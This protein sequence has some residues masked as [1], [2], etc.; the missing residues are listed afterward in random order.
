MP[1]TMAS[2]VPPGLGPSAPAFHFRAL[3]ARIPGRGTHPARGQQP[4]PLTRHREPV[5]HRRVRVGLSAPSQ[6]PNQ[7]RR[8]T[9]LGPS[10]TPA[11][12]VTPTGAEQPSSCLCIGLWVV[13]SPLQ[14][15]HWGGAVRVVSAPRRHSPLIRS[16]HPNAFSPGKECADLSGPSYRAWSWRE[17]S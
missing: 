14:E 12:S 3:T 11:F 1:K 10:W 16:Q 17:L 13:G 2:E 9:N 15:L 4:K 8:A 7:E 5:D 6:L